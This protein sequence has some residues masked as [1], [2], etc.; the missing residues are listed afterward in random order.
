MPKLY[1]V[2]APR[3]GVGGS[4]GGGR[5]GGAINTFHM[6]DSHRNSRGHLRSRFHGSHSVRPLHDYS[7]GLLLGVLKYD[8]TPSYTPCKHLIVADALSRAFSLKEV[9][10]TTKAK[11]HVRVYAVK[12][13]LPVSYNRSG[14]TLSR[15]QR[16]T[17]YS[18]K[19]R[20]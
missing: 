18:N 6:N 4:G 15:R 12:A 9:P 8:F 20:I 13:E 2:V 14:R 11:M 10:R 17:R 1:N 19:I 3:G 16:A 5:G 7:A